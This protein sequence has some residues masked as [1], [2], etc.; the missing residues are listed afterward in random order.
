MNRT[1]CTAIAIAI[2]GCASVPPAPLT[3]ADTVVNASFGKTWDAVVDYFARSS[4]PVK[5]IDRSSGLIAAETTRLA[6]DNSRFAT[7]ANWARKFNP[8]GASFNA[9]VRGDST[10]STVRVTA[11]WLATG[12]GA[13][14]I[15]CQTSDVWEKEFEAA[16]KAKA[17]GEA[18]Q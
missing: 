3:R 7:C 10:R 2:S 8:E 16:I 11:S 6:G 5:T 1:T 4:I 9:L 14:S 15:Q 18:R 17:E 13:P 12:G